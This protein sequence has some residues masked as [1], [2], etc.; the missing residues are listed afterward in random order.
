MPN[1]VIFTAN[2]KGRFKPVYDIPKDVDGGPHVWN[3][4]A[5]L[6]LGHPIR[7]TD[8]G[9]QDDLQTVFNMIYEWDKYPFGYRLVLGSALDGAVVFKQNLS[10][11]IGALGV[12]IERWPTE[13]LKSQFSFLEALQRDNNTMA[14]AWSQTSQNKDA[15]TV[16]KRGQRQKYNLFKDQ[17]HFN[18]FEVVTLYGK[19]QEV[20]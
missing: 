19:P 14:V 10:V 7:K 13:N 3:T 12:F 20:P 2:Q 5:Q 16:V 4:M 1:T 6:A 18:L 17:G 9:G 15:W 8:E 11:Y